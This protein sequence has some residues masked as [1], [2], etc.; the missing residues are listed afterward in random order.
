MTSDKCLTTSDKEKASTFNSYFAQIG[1]TLAK[2][3][4]Q[5]QTPNKQIYRVTPVCSNIEIDNKAILKQFLK[6]TKPGK[7]AGLDNFTA[8]DLHIIGPPAL[9]ALKH[10]FKK[11]LDTLEIPKIWK[12]SRVTCIF[13]SGSKQECENYRPIS[14]LSIPSKIMESIICNTLDKHLQTFNLLY[15]RQWGFRPNRSTKLALLNMTERWR[16]SLDEN[17][18]VAIFFLDFRKAFDCLDH[19][20][21]MRKLSACGVSGNLYQWISSYLE[22][23]QQKTVVNGVVS[24]N[25]YVQTGAPQGSLLGPRLFSLTANDLPDVSNDH[26]EDLFADDTTGTCVSDT[27]DTVFI[28]AQKMVDDISKWSHENS[29]TIHPKKSVIMILSPKQF[30]GPLNKINMD[31]EL[32]SIVTKTK[33]LGV[34]IDD[35]LQWND[36]LSSITKFF[37]VKIKKLYS[38][39]ML[40]TKSLNTIY[41]Q[42]ILPSV[43]YAISLWGNCADNLIDQLDNLHIKAARFVHRIRKNI[44]TNEVLGVAR[45]RSFGE[46]YKEQIAVLTY[47]LQTDQLPLPLAKFKPQ[48]KNRRTLRNN[49]RVVPPKFNK[50]SYKR[51]FAYRSCIVWNQLSN[52]CTSCQ[53]VNSFKTKLKNE[54]YNINFKQPVGARMSNRDFIYY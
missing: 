48:P 41:L 13:K 44:P 51:S 45:W 10:V 54:L 32:V 42:G 52:E 11:S 31:G 24:E 4:Q 35:K 12:T 7:A 23:R 18:F 26:E 1:S 36:H 16:K 33:C 39:R 17:K 49:H 27:I 30:I 3:H 37:S 40:S 53:C 22:E 34:T 20:V 15:E 38:M 28:K 9:E 50:V 14:L 6:L 43:T 8:K 29:L 19:Q 21:I 47:K 5:N 25:E 46:M 2:K